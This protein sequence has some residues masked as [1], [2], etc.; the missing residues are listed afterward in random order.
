[1]NTLFHGDNLDILRDFISD[2]SVDLIYLDPPFNSN[3]DYNVLFKEKSGVA[4]PAQMEAFTD[5]WTWDLTAERAMAEIEV[6][7]PA[8]IVR[9]V[10]ALRDIIGDND[11][12]AYL[13]MMA[14]RLIEL[15]RVLRP[16]GSLYLHC[17]PAAGHYLKV[18][19]DVVFGKDKFRNEIIW[20]RTGA[21]SSANKYG[22]VHDVIL[23]YVKSDLATW[24]HPRAEYEQSY[25]DKYYR[26]DDGDGRRYFPDNLF[27]AGPRNGSSGKPWRGIDPAPKGMHWKFTLESLEELDRAGKIYWPPKGGIPRYKRYLEDLKGLAV[28]DIWADIDPINSQGKERLGYPTQKPLALLDR[29]ISASS[30]PGDVIL[31]PFCGCGTAVAAAEKLGRQ[32]IGIDVTYL[33]ISVMKQRI[34]DHFPDAEFDVQGIPRDV[35]GAV[36]L[37]EQGRYQFQWWAVDALGIN[38]RPFGDGKKGSDRGIDGE[39]FY[40]NESGRPVRGI[41]QVKGGKTGSPD[42]RDFRGTMERE[43]VDLA[44]FVCLQHSTPD[45]R[46]DA[47]SAGFVE[48]GFTGRSHPRIQILTIEDLFDGKRPDIPHQQSAHQAA[49]RIRRNAERSIN[50]PVRFPVSLTTEERAD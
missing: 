15:H 40:S 34:R 25:L 35:T 28:T 37:F 26:H 7:A 33:A 29:I 42:I 14:Q 38:A 46:R 36:A 43:G 22:P 16:S 6:N 44:I 10:N 19:L 8:R 47:A 24:N 13:V 48:S 20:R 50:L 3:R 31:D 32:W 5:T 4:S 30:I 23:Y 27:A 49:P 41:I 11:F 12:M 1:M 18:L 17:D 9:T 45:M 21:H 39:F 2:E